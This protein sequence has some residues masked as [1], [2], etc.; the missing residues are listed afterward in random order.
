MLFE[1]RTY[2]SIGGKIGALNERMAT[3]VLPIFARHGIEALGYWT[4]V[5]GEG[6]KLFYI[7]R[8]RDVADREA[9][10][11]AF[12]DDPD[13]HALRREPVL[14]DYTENRLMRLTG[15][16]PAP[17]TTDPVVEIRIYDTLPGKMQ[18]LNDRF[19]NHTLGLFERHGI[20]S[21]G[22]WTEVVG[23]GNRL[24]YMVGYPD[25]GARQRAWDA[26]LGDPEWQRSR[27]DS[28]AD[29]PILRKVQSSILTRLPMSS[30]N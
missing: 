13:L 8:Y 11:G 15:Y 10:W 16:S 7:L 3:R 30:R 22:Y 24:F 27:A 4:E 23:T 14:L 26:F 28:E 12:Q 21:I 1:A 25:V 2:Y 19:A 20:R 29:G 5:I 17:K 18:A 9:R 6:N